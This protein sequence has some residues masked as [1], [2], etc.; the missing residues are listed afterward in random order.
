[1]LQNLRQHSG[2]IFA[3]VLF[4]L[5]I[6]SF[7]L[8]GVG[9]MF[10][11]YTKKP[12]ATVGGTTIHTEEFDYRLKLVKDQ[13][14]ASTK[15]K[16]KL[17]DLK[18]MGVPQKVLN[19][20]VNKTLEDHE[21]AALGII[22]N[23][24]VLESFVK[25][26]PD[27]QNKKGEFDKAKF[28][29]LVTR[30][31]SKKDFFMNVKNLLKK[32]QLF[33]ALS[34]SIQL[35]KAYQQDLY[36]AIHQNIVFSVV[37]IPESHVKVTASPTD[38]DLE[39]IYKANPDQFTQPEYRDVSVLVIDPKVNQNAV[40]LSQEQIQD[41]YL[42]RKEEFM[43][44]ETRDVIQLTFSSK[45]AAAT[46]HDELA[47]GASLNKIIKKYN[48]KVQKH[49]KAVKDKFPA[50]HGNLIF[51]LSQPGVTD[52]IESSLEKVYFL[53]VV[54]E[55]T[56]EGMQ[57][58]ETIREKIEGDLKARLSHELTDDMRNK[59]EDELAGGKSLAD[60][61]AQFNLTVMKLGLMD[62]A[63]LSPKKE[64]V[65]SDKTSSMKALILENTNA[66]A[67][68][69]DSPVLDL[70]NGEMIVV[71]VDTIKPKT[72]PPLMDIRETVAKYWRD[73]QSQEKAAELSLNMIKEINQGAPV[74]QIAKKHGLKVRTLDPISRASLQ[75]KPFKDDF[76][77]VQVLQK[78]FRQPIH[79]ATYG[80]AKDGFAVIVPTK[81]VP[82]DANSKQETEKVAAFEQSL[83]G[84]IQKDFEQ[85]YLRDL[86]IRFKVEINQSMVDSALTGGEQ[87]S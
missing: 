25:S 15:G 27:F 56:P 3:K 44:P 8:V 18:A 80:P 5:I 86:K 82:H 1:M 47:A 33:G 11:R 48:P 28:T 14:M 79:R 45:E 36:N 63:G 61:S 7:A 55:I 40:I 42:R 83:R 67:E 84:I 10:H 66:M 4:G 6:A 78:G 24:A 49:Q 29:E 31:T 32:Q 35:P 77:G 69:S 12:I 52:V 73:T 46:T 39:H 38:A 70:P 75:E 59:I 34:N 43:T 57:P 23:D 2:G 85:D 19:D 62:Q 16:A 50:A 26:L 54:S 81:F 13:I 41:E 76:V 72:L 51:T 74:S 22:V 87:A 58:L 65:F 37:H 30:G 21:M 17:E 64:S 53:F 68:G 20:M 60:V 9:D 71:H